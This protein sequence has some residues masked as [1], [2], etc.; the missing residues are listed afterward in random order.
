MALVAV[1]VVPVLDDP[2]VAVMLVNVEI[3]I[4]PV[5]VLKVS[6]VLLPVRL[7]D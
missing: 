5:L 4:V 7:L 1:K 3:V 6:V 2:V